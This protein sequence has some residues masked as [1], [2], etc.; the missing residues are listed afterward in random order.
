MVRHLN[1]LVARDQRGKRDDAAVAGV[2]A[3]TLPHIAEQAIL[4]V[5]IERRSYASDILTAQHGLEVMHGIGLL[6]LSRASNHDK[7][8]DRGSYDFHPASCLEGKE[9]AHVHSA[10]S[11]VGATGRMDARR[12]NAAMGAAQRAAAALATN[13]A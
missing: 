2:Q 1:R 9:R 6:R 7:R 4:S 8:C 11:A 12:N 10:Q 3:R 13:T 5:L